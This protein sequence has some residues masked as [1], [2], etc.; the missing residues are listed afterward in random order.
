MDAFQNRFQYWFFCTYIVIPWVTQC[1]H[2]IPS[3]WKWGRNVG[4][5]IPWWKE[6][7]NHTPGEYFLC[8]WQRAGEEWMPRLSKGDSKC[9]KGHQMSVYV[10]R[11]GGREWPVLSNLAGHL[12]RLSDKARSEQARSMDLWFVYLSKIKKPDCKNVAH[13][14]FKK[15]SKRHRSVQRR[16]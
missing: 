8:V 10:V 6:K 3:V 13:V 12:S 5:T 4:K 1:R 14:L 9:V 11:R 15:K 16:K 7:K 2:T